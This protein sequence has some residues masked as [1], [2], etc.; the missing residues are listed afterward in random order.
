MKIYIP[1]LVLIL[2]NSF[3]A[4]TLSQNKGKYPAIFIENN[5]KQLPCLILP[6][7]L[8]SDSIEGQVVINI[9]VSADKLSIKK[10]AIILFVLNKAKQNIYK[11][12]QLQSGKNRYDYNWNHYPEMIKKYEPLMAE[13]LNKIQFITDRSPYYKEMG[14]LQSLTFHINI[15]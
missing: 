12:S 11:Y 9:I 1:I 7:S 5:N 8:K 14:L 3:F 2:S 4:H 6:D 10:S 15:K 13:Y